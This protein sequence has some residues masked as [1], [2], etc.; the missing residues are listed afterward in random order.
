MEEIIVDFSNAQYI[1]TFYNINYRNYVA[2]LARLLT[3]EEEQYARLGEK[4]SIIRDN[5]PIFNL[6][7]TKNMTGNGTGVHKDTL[8]GC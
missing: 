8:L 2:I 5:S 6:R 1:E 4:L 3:L 7:L